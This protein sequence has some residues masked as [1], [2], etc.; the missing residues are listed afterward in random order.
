MLWRYAA[1]NAAAGNQGMLSILHLATSLSSMH[2]ESESV[3]LWRSGFT[4]VKPRTLSGNSL[5]WMTSIVHLSSTV[6]HV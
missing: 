6:I 3:T 5:H 1:L 2:W 4:G